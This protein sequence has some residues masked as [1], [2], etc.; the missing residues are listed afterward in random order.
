MP[1]SSRIRVALAVALM[2][3]GTIGLVVML[4]EGVTRLAQLGVRGVWPK[5]G[6]LLLLV[7]SYAVLLVVSY[8]IA[9]VT[10]GRFTAR[11][12][13]A[14]LL[15]STAILAWS[16]ITETLVSHGL[17]WFVSMALGVTVVSLLLERYL[18]HLS[19]AKQGAT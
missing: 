8:S 3:A 9:G 11:R 19:I 16:G 6:V 1:A 7:L 14:G 17:A 15:A 18:R 10:W 5:L 13:A 2:P 12:V 4:S